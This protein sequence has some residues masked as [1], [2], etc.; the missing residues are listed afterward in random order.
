MILVFGIF[1]IYH[2][3]CFIDI[4]L[5]F[6]LSQGKH[7]NKITKDFTGQLEDDEHIISQL[8]PMKTKK[9][10]FSLGKALVCHYSYFTTLDGLKKYAHI[11]SN[12]KKISETY[13]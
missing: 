2:L 10:S 13:L 3:R 6:F 12:Y 4:V 8:I 5:I 9:H 1:I 11:L 7:V